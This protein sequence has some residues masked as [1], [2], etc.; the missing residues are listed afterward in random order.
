M[1]VAEEKESGDVGLKV[2]AQYLSQSPGCCCNL[3]LLLF[4][5][6]PFVLQGCLQF[7]IAA[8]ASA[9]FPQQIQSD[10]K[11]QFTVICVT[12]LGS[13]GF[14]AFLIGAI[15]LHL[16]N[17]LHNS[18]LKRVTRAPMLFFNSNPLG[19]I[20]NRFSKDTATADNTVTAYLLR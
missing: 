5:I 14:T 6:T 12:L 8:W 1:I 10:K 20:I 7:F 16:S 17:T 11:V 9:P 13:C 19:R 15:F 2:Y 18:M 4:A 3:G